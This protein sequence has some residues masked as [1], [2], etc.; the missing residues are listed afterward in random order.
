MESWSAYRNADYLEYGLAFLPDSSVG[1]N[2]NVLLGV[3]Y[4]YVDIE[5]EDGDG[6]G[7]V[8]LRSLSLGEIAA[9]NS[10]D[11]VTQAQ[12]CLTNLVLLPHM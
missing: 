12:A 9:E 8:N 1:D 6:D 5:A 3:R 2:L 11:A 7:S 4:D 10:D